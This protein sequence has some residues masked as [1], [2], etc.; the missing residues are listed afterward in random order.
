MKPQ[1]CPFI[2]NTPDKRGPLSVI[3]DAAGTLPCEPS[4]ADAGRNISDGR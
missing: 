3:R 1:E 2:Q 4:Y